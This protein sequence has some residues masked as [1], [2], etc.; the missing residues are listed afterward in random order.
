MRGRGGC[1]GPGVGAAAGAVQTPP[2]AMVGSGQA[3]CQHQ[4]RWSQG[5][6]WLRAPGSPSGAQQ[7]YFLVMKDSRA[8]SSAGNGEN[9]SGDICFPFQLIAVGLNEFLNKC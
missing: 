3:R 8:L 5:A 6:G 4:T 1:R 9:N 7:E 2:S